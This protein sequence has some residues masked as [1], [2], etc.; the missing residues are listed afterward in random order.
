MV[1]PWE[2]S[3]YIDGCS[4]EHDLDILLMHLAP[5]PGLGA[6]TDCTSVALVAPLLNIISFLEPVV[7]LPDLIQ[8]FVDTQMTWQFTM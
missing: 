3:C 4:F 1:A 7:P 5:I 8:G 6:V 2:G